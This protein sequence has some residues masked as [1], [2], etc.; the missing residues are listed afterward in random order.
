ML[1][2]VQHPIFILK[3]FGFREEPHCE[4]PSLD[5]LLLLHFDIGRVKFLCAGYDHAFDLF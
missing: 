4:A 1:N 3:M 5:L 2:L